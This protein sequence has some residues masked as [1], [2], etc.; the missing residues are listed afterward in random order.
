MTTS[1]LMAIQT[2]T[3]DLKLTLVYQL[4]NYVFALFRTVDQLPI[5]LANCQ[6]HS[7]N[8]IEMENEMLSIVATLEEFQGMLLGDLHVFTYHKNLIFDTLKTQQVL[9]WCN[10]VEDLSHTL[11]YIE[12]SCIILADVL[13]RLN[14]LVTQAQILEGKSHIDPTVVSNDKNELYFLEQDYLGLSDA[15]IRETLE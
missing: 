2:T 12:D 13:S 10:K 3:K 11:H 4:F 15:E 9:H 6:N 8:Y 7:K 14:G 5:S 1:A